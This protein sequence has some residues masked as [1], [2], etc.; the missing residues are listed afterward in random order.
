MYKRQD[1]TGH[2]GLAAKYYTHF[3]SPIRRYP[4]L[5][6]HRI[7]KDKLRGRLEREGKTEHYKEILEDVA[8]QS[9]VCERRA[10]EA[11]RESDKLKKAEYM[12]YHIG[13]E[14]EGIISGVTGWGFYVELPNT[15]EGL[16]HVN[17]L[18]DDYYTFDQDAYELIGDV[19]HKVFALGQKV[20]VRVADADTML[21]TVDFV[22][23]ED[24]EW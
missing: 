15:V 13:E 20:R 23:A 5:Q 2:F 14:F 1:N 10:D 11:E 22:L 18:R 8:R 21:K 17:T 16:V 7:I 9:S 3:T 12:S 6:I 24:Q 4:D 19:T